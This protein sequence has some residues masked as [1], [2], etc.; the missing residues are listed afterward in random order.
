MSQ[1]PTED[2]D[3]A[4]TREFLDKMKQC[5]LKKKWFGSKVDNL[6]SCLRQHFTADPGTLPLR[7]RMTWVVI[8]LEFLIF[9]GS[10]VLLVHYF[11]W[12]LWVCLVVAGIACLEAGTYFGWVGVGVYVREAWLEQDEKWAGRYKE[13]AVHDGMRAAVSL[14]AAI[15]LFTLAGLFRP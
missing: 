2:S 10:W 11:G 12:A 8:V 13:L 6:R 3:F 15:G 4:V 1:K 9:V 5:P 14:A 7:K